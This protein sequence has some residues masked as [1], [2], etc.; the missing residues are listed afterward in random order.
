LSNSEPSRK[1]RSCTFTISAYRGPVQ[2][3]ILDWAGTTV[4]FGS[5]APVAAFTQLFAAQGVDLSLDEVRGPMGTEK[6]EHIRRLCA[7]CPGSPPPGATGA[8]ATGRSD[9]RS[10]LP[11]LCAVADRRD[12][13]LT[14]N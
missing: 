6:R 3:V 14:R 7:N 13:R 12:S 4:D 1:A 8:A 10:T 5:L 2:A 9:H 11:G